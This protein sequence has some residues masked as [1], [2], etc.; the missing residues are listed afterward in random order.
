M[1][2]AYF[3]YSQNKGRDESYLAKLHRL[4]PFN[5]EL[6]EAKLKDNFLYEMN[7]RNH[8]M[9]VPQFLYECDRPIYI[10]ED[11]LNELVNIEESEKLIGF[12][13][14]RAIS[15]FFK[16]KTHTI[17]DLELIFRSQKKLINGANN[18]EFFIKELEK[19]GYFKI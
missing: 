7:D 6:I 9:L 1:K 2:R 10:A 8:R 19:G 17:K 15:E 11:A 5:I 16:L 18:M 4:V 14:I 13:S 3:V 12:R